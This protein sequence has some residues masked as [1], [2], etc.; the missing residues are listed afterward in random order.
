MK[1]AESKPAIKTEKMNFCMA[2]KLTTQ[3]DFRKRAM[4]R[5]IDSF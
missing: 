1:E 2:I 4:M 5:V 3:F